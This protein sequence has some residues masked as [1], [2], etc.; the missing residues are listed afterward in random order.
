MKKENGPMIVIEAPIGGGKS[1]LT[2]LLSNVLSSDAIFEPIAD[3]ELL[4]KFYEDKEKYGFMFQVSM[5]SKRF[6]LIKK[7]LVERNSILDRSIYGDRVF[8]DLLV[9]RGEME[10][11]EANVY[12][13]LLETMLEELEYIPSKT[14]DLM[15]YIDL[16][17]DL[18]LE[19]IQSRGRDFEQIEGDPG[20]LEY[21]TQ[22]NEIYNGWFRKF[23]LCPKIVIDATK[24]DFVNNEQDKKDVLSF[25]VAELYRVK[26]V[27]F[28]ELQLAYGKIHGIKAKDSKNLI[29][30]NSKILEY[31]TKEI[32]KK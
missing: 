30:I 16:P 11:V 18:E 17:L 9:K 31:K 6:D 4:E 10:Q 19:R 8:V 14:P 3:N 28:K 27:T 7:A 1:N 32:N 24:Y 25:I 20:L 15:A 2:E 29:E 5:V 23:D 13:D 26:A 21:Y 12:Y 22:H